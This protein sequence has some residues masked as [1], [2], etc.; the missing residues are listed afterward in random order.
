MVAASDLKDPKKD[1]WGGD[2]NSS[3]ERGLK[4]LLD[5]SSEEGGSNASVDLPVYY[6]GTRRSSFAPYWDVRTKYSS[7]SEVEWEVLRRGNLLESVF[8]NMKG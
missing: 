5:E 8:C 4:D 6:S 1:A 2:Y 3:T 7:N